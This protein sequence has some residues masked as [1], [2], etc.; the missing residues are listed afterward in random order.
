MTFGPILKHVIACRFE[1]QNARV[2]IRVSLQ[3]S[4]ISDD[5]L[6]LF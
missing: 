1:D 4:Y 2:F 5:G 3:R 6:A